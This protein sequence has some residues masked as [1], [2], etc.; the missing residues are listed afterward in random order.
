MGDRLLL[1]LLSSYY[2]IRPLRDEMGVRGSENALLLALRRDSR[3]Y[4]RAQPALRIPRI[5]PY[6]E[7][8]RP[9]RLPRPP[10]DAHRLLGTPLL[11]AAGWHLPVAQTFFIWASIFNLFPPCRSSGASWPTSSVLSR[12][13]GSSRLS[14]SAADSRSRRRGGADCDTRRPPR[15]DEPHPSSAALLLEGAVFC[16]R[17]L[18]RHFGVDDPIAKEAR[19]RFRAGRGP[20]RQRRPLG[21]HD[22]L[23]LR[24]PPRHISLPPPLRRQLDLPLLRAGAHREGGSRRLLTADRVLRPN[25]PLGEPPHRIHAD[26]PVGAVPSGPWAARAPFVA[27][28]VLT[29]V[30]F[31]ALAVSP[32]TG[33]LIFVMVSRRA[34]NFALFRPA[35]EVLF[36]VLPRRGRCTTIMTTLVYRWAT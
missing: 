34:G 35:R 24:L 13:G 3:R 19:G 27:L 33:V 7:G 25:R 9:G 30:G 26:I 12:A 14:R 2:V 4:G 22:R 36:T 18:V 28:P 1:L 11:R 32:T 6:A 10:R 23:P 21:P 31:V 16:V 5:A 17:G 15:S 29:A 20:A 8:L